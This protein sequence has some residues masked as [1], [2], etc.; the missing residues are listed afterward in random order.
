MTKEIEIKIS[1]LPDEVLTKLIIEDLDKLN[2]QELGKVYKFIRREI[3][4]GVRN[5]K[6]T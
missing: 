3:I 4:S 1:D 5:E 2:I 6:R